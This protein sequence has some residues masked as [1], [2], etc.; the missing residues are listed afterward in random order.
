[1]RIL[2]VDDDLENVQLVANVLRDALSTE[3][4]LVTTVE[5][6]VAALH[7]A[8]VQIVVADLFI[9]MG[10]DARA[11]LGPRARKYAEQVEDLG[12]LVLLDEID[13]VE[14]A[15]VVLLHT[16]C[17]DHVLLNLLGERVSAR[18]RKPAPT[19]V[20]LNAVL[21]AMRELPPRS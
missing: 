8:P 10:P 15:P 21:E 19:E 1:M 5:D 7:E 4:I 2:F 16:A 9:P 3:C 18:V 6:A 13:R 14:P 12:G 11:S 17:R 20:L